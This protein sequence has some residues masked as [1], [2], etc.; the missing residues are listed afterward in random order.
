MA[1]TLGGLILKVTDFRRLPDEQGGKKRRTVGGQ[2]RGDSLWT[3]RAWDASVIADTDAEAASIR[4]QADGVTVRSFAG[5]LPGATVNV[6]A[7]VTGD[8]YQR[9]PG[10]WFRVLTLSIREAL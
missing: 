9:T 7:E 3:A 1:T 8:S 4:T 6:K 2:L 10:G 5:D